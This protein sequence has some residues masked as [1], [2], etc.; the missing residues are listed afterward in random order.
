MQTYQITLTGTQPLLMHADDIDWADQMEAW[1]VDK[2]NKKKSKAG[3]DRSPAH[4]WIGS[5]YRNEAGEVV[6][7]TENTMRALMEGGAMVLVPGGRGGKT[8]KAQTQ[9]G[10]MPRE[11]GWP[12][13]INGKPIPVA[14]IQRLLKEADFSVHRE[15]VKEL[16]FSLFLKRARIGQSKHI[17]VRPRFE[18]WSATGELVVIDEQITQ[19]ILADILEVAGKY[20][21]LGDWRPSSKTPGTFGM[22]SAQL[23]QIQ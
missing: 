21:G 17:R 4:R 9:S 7:P 19:E 18:N 2:D 10:I 15:A 5:L 14:P 11:I 20:K 23:R 8:F 3:D 1:K 22:F 6:I 16:G 13:L 12:L